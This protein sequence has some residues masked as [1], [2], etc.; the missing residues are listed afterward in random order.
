MHS[1][2]NASH[3]C[4]IDAEALR[5]NTRHKFVEEFD[6]IGGLLVSTL[7]VVEAHLV[8]DRFKIFYQH[9]IVSGE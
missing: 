2:I 9:M 8:W 3:L 6:T 4:D 7:H 1:Y 5:C